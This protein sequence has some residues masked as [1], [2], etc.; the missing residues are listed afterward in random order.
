[1]T[2][3][4]DVVILGIPY[5]YP[6][7]L[8][9]PVLLSACLEKHGI[10]AI[11]LDLNIDFIE[12]FYNNPKWGVLKNAITYNSSA[13]KLPRSTV[14]DVIRFIR[15]KL[16]EIRNTHNPKIIGLSIFTNES[17]NFSYLTIPIIRSVMPD[18]KIMVGGRGM[19]NV[20]RINNMPFYKV[21]HTHGMV[22]VVVVGD[23]E[24][25]IVD[26]VKNDQTGIVYSP[27]QTKQDL[28]NI[29][30]A[31]WE[32]YD[33]KK[34]T[35]YQNSHTYTEPNYLSITASK[36]CVRRCSF[37]DVATFWPEYIFRDGYSV[38]EEIINAYKK[39]GIKTF[40]FTD[41]LING[42][43]TEYRKMNQMLAQ[44]IPNTINYNG[45]AIFRG[46]NQMPDTDF[47]LASKAGCDL[48]SVG[49]E[50]GS[51]AV[52]YHMR[53][54]ITNDDMDHSVKQLYRVGI[55]QKHLYIVGY[56]TETDDDFEQTL[57]ALRRYQ[58]MRD[59]IEVQVTA[60]FQMLEASPLLKNSLFH[61]ELGIRFPYPHLNADTHL[62]TVDINP[63]NT[64]PER[65]RRYDKFIETLQVC[66]YHMGSFMNHNGGRDRMRLQDLLDVYDAQT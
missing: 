30:L 46:A 57:D 59:S 53:K 44:E 49:V 4:K 55:K 48:W 35:N 14:V 51:E 65:V 20:C 45:Y 1:M 25:S 39:T 61:D 6:S 13:E 28:D 47:E 43:V 40:K 8:V 66:G 41:N 24:F 26:A 32:N 36:G 5:T 60:T 63:T 12:H 37:C 9:A 56:P 27:Q 15:K 11:G 42:S 29:P 23:S 33:L 54:K 50:S 62:W 19:E 58:H 64:F 31:N 10:S 21:Y 7:P 38:A 17:V 3:Q 18:V 34:Y 16:V 52:R 2:Q 22:D